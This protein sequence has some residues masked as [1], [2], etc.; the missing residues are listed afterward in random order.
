MYLKTHRRKKDGKEHIYYSLT[1]S[2]RI[3]KRRVVQRRILNLGE[4]NT[5]QVEAWQRTIEVIHENGER[6]DAAFH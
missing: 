2:V 4:L 3:N 1:E 6:P 5:N